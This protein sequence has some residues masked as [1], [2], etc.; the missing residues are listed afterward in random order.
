MR[1]SQNR[2]FCL[3]EKLSQDGKEKK[4]GGDDQNSGYTSDSNEQEPAKN[5]GQGSPQKSAE[6]RHMPQEVALPSNPSSAMETA[7]SPGT[8]TGQPGQPN[9][10]QKSG[11]DQGGLERAR[12]QLTNATANTN[13]NSATLSVELKS[14]MNTAVRHGQPLTAASLG[15]AAAAHS[16]HQGEEGSTTTMPRQLAQ[17][18][19][20]AGANKMTQAGVA[21]ILGGA[22][23]VDAQLSQQNGDSIGAQTYA[24][25]GIN[26]L[27]A[28]GQ[29]YRGAYQDAITNGDVPAA[30]AAAC[31]LASTSLQA[32]HLA[33]TGLISDSQVA[34]ARLDGPATAQVITQGAAE[35][36]LSSPTVMIAAQ[37]ANGGNQ[38]ELQSM[39]NSLPGLSDFPA[40]S[41]PAATLTAVINSA[42]QSNPSMDSVPVPIVAALSRNPNTDTTAS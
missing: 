42:A 3:E 33:S 28:A 13:E 41:S 36:G 24:N 25:K 10:S 38:G 29:A 17:K 35:G 15:L 39:I 14:A 12:A 34:G 37:T 6:R 30:E 9:A 20:V 27:S 40:P 4:Q 23:V 8:N 5:Q 26:N 32:R 31:G 2:D 1:L 19:N 7:Q 16:L 22:D 11:S 18:A 21:A